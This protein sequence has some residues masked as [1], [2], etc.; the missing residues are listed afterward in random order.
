VTALGVFVGFLCLPALVLLFLIAGR[1]MTPAGFVL[2]VIVAAVLV[3]GGQW[4][5]QRWQRAAPNI[6]ARRAANRNRR[7]AL[8]AAEKRLHELYGTDDSESK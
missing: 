1:E 6:W 5:C 3:L 4:Q 2:F 8:T 7:A